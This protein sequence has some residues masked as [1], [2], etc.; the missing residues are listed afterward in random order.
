[1]EDHEILTQLIARDFILPA[2]AKPSKKVLEIVAELLA[3]LISR[4]VAASH[5]VDVLEMSPTQLA[6]RLALCCTR[7]VQRNPIRQ[8]AV[9]LRIAGDTL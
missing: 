9:W 6:Q 5:A 2:L 3:Q 1:L 8:L 4:L 7:R